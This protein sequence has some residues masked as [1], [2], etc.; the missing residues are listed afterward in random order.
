MEPENPSHALF[1]GSFPSGSCAVCQA[2][3]VLWFPSASQS[4]GVSFEGEEK[5]GHQHRG[6]LFE[7]RYYVLSQDHHVRKCPIRLNPSFMCIYT[8]ARHSAIA[9][10]WA[11]PTKLGTVPTIDL[12]TDT[13]CRFGAGTPAPAQCIQM[14]RSKASGQ[15][16][17]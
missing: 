6:H 1:C 7:H 16:Q 12:L 11:E 4:R 2:F 5:K 17:R 3:A 8:Q 15:R 9:K 10:G 14:L 13:S